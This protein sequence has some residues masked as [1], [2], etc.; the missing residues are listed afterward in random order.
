MIIQVFLKSDLM[1][2][3]VM[4]ISVAIFSEQVYVYSSSPDYI[5]HVRKLCTIHDIV[6]LKGFQR[7]VVS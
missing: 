1:Y 4:L 5:V 6:S 2:I 7:S 3:G